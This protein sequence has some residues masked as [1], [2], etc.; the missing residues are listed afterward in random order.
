MAKKVAPVMQADLRSLQWWSAPR[1]DNGLPQLRTPEDVSWYS[2][3]VSPPLSLCEKRATFIADAKKLGVITSAVIVAFEHE[4]SLYQNAK[5]SKL[6]GDQKWVTDVLKSGTISDRVAALALVVQESPI[7]E[8]SA[9][10]A[11]LAMAS[12]KEYRTSQLALEALKDLLI[13]NLLPD[14]RLVPFKSQ[15][16]LHPEM[17]MQRAMSFWYEEQLMNRMEVV[18]IALEVGL[19]SNIEYFKKQ[20]MDI[21]ADLLM[22]KPERES[23]FLEMLV[24]K[25]GDPS[26]AVGSKCI[27]LLRN[28]VRNHPAMKGIIVRE[29]RQLI[30]RPN[31][32]VRVVHSGIIFLSQVTLVRGDHDVAA[33]L[34][35]CYMSLFEKA[36]KQDELGSRLLSS[37]L[38]GLDRAFPYL[39]NKEPIAK[40]VDSLFRIVHSASFTTTT[41]AL[42]LISHIAL[43]DTTSSSAGEG[44]KV[45]TTGRFSYFLTSAL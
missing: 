42:M 43:S 29:V 44:S 6:S 35:E 20:C 15:P 14:R 13:H 33:Q 8:L 3:E 31:L 32:G 36:V 45:S 22:G 18:V 25:L 30:Y 11:L 34:V 4:V 12:R 37:L 9:L 21:A 23:K 10:D 27:E 19:K 16:L 39:D 1:D 7:H 5:G 24:N 28:V 2:P 17:T 40:H 41:R 26:G 38:S